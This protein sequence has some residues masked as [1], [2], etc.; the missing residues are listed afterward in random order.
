MFDGA[1]EDEI[2]GLLDATLANRDGDAAD[3]P[4]TGKAEL[5]DGRTGEPFRRAVTSARSTS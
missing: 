3:R 5:F 4:T 2:T 1:R